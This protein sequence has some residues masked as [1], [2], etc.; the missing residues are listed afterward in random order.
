MDKSLID[1]F[2]DLF[3]EDALKL[4]E[5]YKITSSRDLRDDVFDPNHFSNFCCGLYDSN[6]STRRADYRIVRR[7]IIEQGGSELSCVR[8]SRAIKI[9][10][11]DE[12][13]NYVS[14]KVVQ[15]MEK[16][17]ISPFNLKHLCASVIIKNFNTYS[18]DETARLYVACSRFEKL[19]SL[20][21]RCGP[22]RSRR[23]FNFLSVLKNLN[24]PRII[25]SPFT[26]QSTYYYDNLKIDLTPHCDHCNGLKDFQQPTCI[27]KVC[28]FLDLSY[29]TKIAEV[30]GHFFNNNHCE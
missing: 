9:N 27:C 20:T 7:E 19:R 4:I 13:I 8:Q 29:Y 28:L 3:N 16:K 10:V 1:L 11:E 30:T 14:M 24:Y 17:T 21:F 12:A 25:D 22:P 26:I 6:E 5:I 23:A 15:P 2:Q 18:V